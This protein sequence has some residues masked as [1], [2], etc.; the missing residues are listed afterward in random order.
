MEFAHLSPKKLIDEPISELKDAIKAKKAPEPTRT[1]CHKKDFEILPDSPA[2]ECIHVIV[3]P[4]ASTAT[5]NREQEL[6]DQVASLQALLNKSVHGTPKRTKGFK[7]TVNIEHATLDVLKNSI[8]AINQ[9]PALENDGAVL[10]M[11]NESGNTP[12]NDQDLREMLQVFVTKSSFKF[13]V[14]IET[15]SKPSN[16]WTFPKCEKSKAVVKHLMAEL[17]T[18]SRCYSPRQEC[19]PTGRVLGVIEVKKEDFMKGFAQASVQMESTL[20]RKRKADE[21]DDGRSIDRVFGIVTD[22]SEWW[23]GPRSYCLVVGGGAK[24]DGSF[25][26]W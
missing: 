25:S 12:R 2:E 16:E 17:K 19:R 11:L 13:T 21:I 23:K 26:K 22:A 6:L 5:S 14:L 8:R 10:N 1:T 18:S 7:W 20:S 24:A 4:P 9:T 15:S 3:E